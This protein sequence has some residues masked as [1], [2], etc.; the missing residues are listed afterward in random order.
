M[1]YSWVSQALDFTQMVMDIRKPHKIAIFI[2]PINFCF[3]NIT[4]K[5]FPGTHLGL[6]LL[7]GV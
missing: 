6:A 4:K 2:I 3:N 5:S 7:L 1:P